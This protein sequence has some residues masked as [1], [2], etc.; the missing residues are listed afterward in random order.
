MKKQILI[1]IS[2]LFVFTNCNAQQNL[3]EENYVKQEY[4]IKMRDGTKL[5]TSVYTPKDDSQNYPII[6]RRTPYSAAP[7]G[8]SNYP[9]NIDTWKHLIEE[10][11]IFVFQDVRGRFMSEGEY[12]NMRP[13]IPN[14]S[15][16]TFAEMEPSQK[17]R[18]DHRYKAFKKIKKFF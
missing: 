7:Y 14:K 15:K 4:K 2:I 11:Y 6:L 13:Y 5:F 9:K 17:Y 3:L 16:K 12:V 10:G 18:L 1:F 8:I